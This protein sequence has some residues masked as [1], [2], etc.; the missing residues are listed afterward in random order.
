MERRR[1]ALTSYPERQIFVQ[2]INEAIAAG[3]RKS[4]AC[5]TACISIR[6]LQRWCSKEGVVGKD[7]RPD[8]VRPTP[9]NKLSNSERMRVVDVC[10]EDEYSSVPP[11]QIVPKLADKGEYIA[12]E[13]TF[14]RILKALGLLK[15]RGRAKP[16]G[17]VKRPTSHTAN[18]PN[19]TWTWDISYLPSRVIGQF[20]YLY[21]IVDIYSR[22]IGRQMAF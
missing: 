6:T 20:F 14:Y 15:H 13:S 5:E 19:E 17:S 3:A 12:S 22:K 1:G 21:M 8:A 7:R 11:S 9:A 10:S 4:K 16:K 18:G 2:L